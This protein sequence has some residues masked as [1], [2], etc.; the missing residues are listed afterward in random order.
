ME[1]TDTD[2]QAQAVLNDLYRKMSPSKKLEGVFSAYQTGKILAIAG[3]KANNQQSTQKQLWHLWAKQ[4]LGE[5]LYE[6]VYRG[7][8]DE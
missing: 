7:F 5:G 4:H 3:L 1:K 8:F 6:K 2:K